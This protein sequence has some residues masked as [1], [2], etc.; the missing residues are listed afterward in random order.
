MSS[1]VPKQ[2]KG[3]EVGS[4]RGSQKGKAGMGRLVCHGPALWIEEK[5]RESEREIWAV[6]KRSVKTQGHI[7]LHHASMFPCKVLNE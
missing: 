2:T 4:G 3:G 6:K 7:L 5:G 1:G